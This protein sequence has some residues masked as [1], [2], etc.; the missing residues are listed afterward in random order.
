MLVAS[1]AAIAAAPT[2]NASITVQPSGNLGVI[3]GVVRDEGGSPIGD[4]IVAIFRAGTSKLLKQVSS[5]SDGSFLAKVMPGTYTVL[6]VAQGFNPVTL[7]GVEIGRSVEVNQGFKLER[8]GSGNTL[9][10]KHLDRNSSKW[11]IRAAQS[12]RSIYQHGQ[13]QSPVDENK[14]AVNDADVDDR[15]DERSS[16]RHG[17]TVVETYFAGSDHGSYGGVNFATL[18]PVNE[19]IDVVLAGQAGLGKNAPQRFET[20]VKFRPTADHQIRLDSSFGRTGYVATGNDGRQLGQLSFQALD[21]WKIRDGVI[22]VLGV[23]YSRFTGAGNDASLS[24]RIGLQFDVD[25]KTRFRSAFTT[26]TEEKTWARSVDLEGESVAFSEPVSIEDLSLINGKP[27]MNK[28]RRLEFG[29]E[30]VLDNNSSIEANAFFDA[31]LGRGVGLNSFSFDTLGGDG[32]SEFVANQQGRSSGLRVVYSRRLSG[33]WSTSAG[34]AFGNGQKL[35]KSAL[36]NPSNVF[37]GDFFQSFFAQLA[38]DLKTGT[39][40]KTVFRLSPQA[41]VFAIDPFKG[42]LAIYDP[43]LS[44]VV[45]QSLPTLGLPIRAEAI[46]DARNLFDFQTA[47]FGEEGSLGL[48][49]Q[50]RM[51]RGGIQVRF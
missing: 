34:Y 39:S 37:E 5:S 50:R 24:P 48:N 45:T 2:V 27:Q 33:T 16:G 29:I 19:K 22:L 42:R 3:R 35:S 40:V 8:A 32:F 18:M 12:Q 41:T 26:Q 9:G 17:Q 38:A 1:S 20:A 30:R 25:A 13:G 51:L 6:A 11:R 43:G 14:T 7:L 49:A 31:T 23:D 44:V 21:E 4:A 46:I 47:V 28:S 10:E 15:S 36:T